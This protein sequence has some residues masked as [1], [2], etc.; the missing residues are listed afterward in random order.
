MAAKSYSPAMPSLNVARSRY[1]PRY[2]SFAT[3]IIVESRDP[4]ERL[5]CTR[6][7][8]IILQFAAVRQ[9]PL[10]DKPGRI[11]GK[12]AFDNLPGFDRD[13]GFMAAVDRAKMRR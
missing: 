10:P 12:I 1:P 6:P 4:G 11:A 3:L 2:L 8:P 9:C 5:A 13:V 7:S